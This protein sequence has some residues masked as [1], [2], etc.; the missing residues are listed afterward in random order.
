MTIDLESLGPSYTTTQTASFRRAPMG[1]L[2]VAADYV[3][4]SQIDALDTAWVALANEGFFKLVNVPKNLNDSFNA[5]WNAYTKWRDTQ[6]D[7]VKNTATG[8]AAQQTAL[9]QAKS[10]YAQATAAGAKPEAK[11]VPKVSTVTFAPE[12]VTAGTGAV[13]VALGLAFVLLTWQPRRRSGGAVMAGLGEGKAPKKRVRFSVRILEK[14][15][16]PPTNEALIASDLRVTVPSVKRVVDT[17]VKYGDVERIN[18]PG[19]PPHLSLTR[20]GLEHLR[21]QKPDWWKKRSGFSGIETKKYRVSSVDKYHGRNKETREVEL[22]ADAFN[23]KKSLGRAL[24]DAGILMSGQTV[25]SFRG[26]NAWE[27]GESIPGRNLLTGESR[28]TLSPY[29]ENPIPESAVIVFPGNAPGLTTGYHSIT[30]TPVKS[31]G[32]S[33]LSVPDRHQLRILK[34]TVRNPAKSFLGGPS[35]AEAEE[36]LRKK[37][38]FTNEQIR[39][40]KEG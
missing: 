29:A 20:K 36:I 40:L 24:R 27:R 6:V 3:P 34:D 4:S 26:P 16:K 22:H 39:K 25:R 32:M 23:T 15:S 2:G 1:E 11:V 30:L 13:L 17:L 14:I 12:V 7:I 5:I 28:P 38:R 18:V 21:E 9:A 19:Y 10:I 37:Y 31:G 8:F 33:G 35:A